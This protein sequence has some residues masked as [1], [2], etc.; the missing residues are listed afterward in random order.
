MRP[1]VESWIVLLLVIGVAGLPGCTGDDEDKKDGAQKQKNGGSRRSSQRDRDRRDRRS[2]RRDEAD[3]PPEFGP[4]MPSDVDPMAEGGRRGR[5]GRGDRDEQQVGSPWAQVREGT[6]WTYEFADGTTATYRVT[7][8]DQD[9]AHCEMVYRDAE[10][11][12]LDVRQGLLPRRMSREEYEEKVGAMGRRGREKDLQ[13]AGKN[14]ECRV[15]ERPERL[16]RHSRRVERWYYC[17]K[18]PGGI[19]LKEVEQD[20]GPREIFRLKSYTN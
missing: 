8:V 13:V 16:D 20:D 12:Q 19:V 17:L 6:T 15:Y 10:G 9:V 4:G 1:L 14:L 11:E 2:R 7:K 18:V 5:R 3:M